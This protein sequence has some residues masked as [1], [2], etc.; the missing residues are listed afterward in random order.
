MAADPD[1]KPPVSPLLVR[2]LATAP[3]TVTALRPTTAAPPAPSVDL[4][5]LFR[6]LE[7]AVAAALPPPQAQAAAS[8][9][10]PIRRAI[11]A[12]DAARDPRGLVPAFEQVE[13]L[14]EAMLL[15]RPPPPVPG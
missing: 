9:L 3:G 12:G 2:W 7:Q 5:Q 6:E 4:A 1:P 10:E 15:T 11:G 13:D 14:L 8:M